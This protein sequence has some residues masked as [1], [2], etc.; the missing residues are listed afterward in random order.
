[1]A[2]PVKLDV[3]GMWI[4]PGV[5]LTA[6]QALGRPLGCRWKNIPK[7]IEKDVMISL[8]NRK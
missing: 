7:N 8:F 2:F 1:M 6:G 5:G 3:K 4:I